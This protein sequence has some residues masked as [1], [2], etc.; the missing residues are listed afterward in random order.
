LAGAA[1]GLLII[2]FLGPA[3]FFFVTLYLVVAYFIGFY[4]IANAMSVGEVLFYIFA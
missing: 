2:L 3:T 1:K 4:I